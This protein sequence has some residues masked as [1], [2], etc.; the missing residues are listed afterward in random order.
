[1]LLLLAALL[2]E[3]QGGETL[4]I[5][6]VDLVRGLISRRKLSTVDDLIDYLHAVGKQLTDAKPQELVTG[7]MVRRILRI[8]RQEG[9]GLVD[10]IEKEEE[11]E[12]S[13]ASSQQHSVSASPS[14]SP[15]RSLSSSPPPSQSIKRSFSTVDIDVSLSLHSLLDQPSAASSPS[16]LSLDGLPDS[17]LAATPTSVSASSLSSFVSSTAPLPASAKVSQSPASRRPSPPPHPPVLS[18]EEERQ[19]REWLNSR[20][21]PAIIEEIALLMDELHLSSSNIASQATEHIYANETILVYGMSALVT[22]FLKEAARFRR[23]EVLVVEGAP[24]FGGHE[25]AVLLSA[26][27]SPIETTVIT[28]SAVYALMPAVNKVIISCHAVMANGSL[29]LPAGGH[30]VCVAARAHSVPVV[31]LTGLHQLCTLYAH[32][33]DRFDI[34]QSPSQLL[35]YEGGL[36][37]STSVRVHN[38]VYEEVGAAYVSLL[39][40]NVGGHSPS[41]IY[42]LLSDHYHSMDYT[43]RGAAGGGAAGGAVGGRGAAAVEERSGEELNG[44]KDG[45]KGKAGGKKGKGAGAAAAGGKEKRKAPNA[46]MRTVMEGS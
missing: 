2:S 23:F 33:D 43:L 24:A 45:G 5:L 42:R 4:A 44:R 3:L 8:V 27:P 31:V 13:A 1:M 36:A 12:R 10:E 18:K 29:I 30:N 22:A 32:Q 34:Q 35:D 46:D 20:L 21:K 16:L 40:T 17:P 14:A 26:A 39:I 9:K 19:Q 6:T 25:Q 41:Y 38:P 7:N 11:R 37:A 28:D 15:P